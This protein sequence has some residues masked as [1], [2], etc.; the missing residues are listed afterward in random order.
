MKQILRQTRSVCP[1]CLKNLPAQ[2]VRQANGEIFLQKTCG[3]HGDYSVPVW[4]GL[5][6]FDLW[7]KHTDPLNGNAGLSC[8]DNCG[9]CGEHEIGTCCCLLEV[10]RRCNLSCRFC[11]ANGG[12]FV[13]DPTVEEL[14]ADTRDIVAKCGKVLLQLS[15][16]EPTLRSDLPHLVRYAKEAGCGYVQLNTNGIRLAQEP[17]YAKAL[18][19]AGLDIVFLQ[20]DG[21]RD[22]IYETLRGKP[23]LEC[24]KQA[25]Q[26]CGDLGIGVTLVP[27]VVP[28][29]NTD[30][31]GSMIRFAAEN[32][33]YVRGIHF[34]PVS[35]FGRYPNMPDSDGR[36][37]L[38]QLM[39]D[40]SDQT[41]IPMES[42]MPSRCDHPLCGFHANYLVNPN[43]TLR[44]LT[45][46]TH[47]AKEKG[48]ARDNR[49]Y[50]A[51]HWMR[52][53]QEQ[54]PTVELADEMDFDTFLYRLRHGS[55]NLSAMAFQ[56][57]MNL[58]MERLHRC[59]LHVYDHGTVKPFC[60]NYLTGID[61][62]N[63]TGTMDL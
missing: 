38:D 32:V 17:E 35:Y 41:G 36:Y 25:I 9:I 46:I 54:A 30:D 60:A 8:P 53:P 3:E 12:D 21:T 13:E 61:E 58:N 50:V 15:G 56:D 27:T 51:R 4:R 40:I 42:F 18:A 45:S 48:C 14:E 63:Q 5:V 59:S 62:E 31:L 1:V 10:T 23:L 7:T 44:A 55:L 26:V 11:F 20:F 49:E 43:G 33:P 28:G 47:S 22:N 2:L 29:V 16:G 6:D 37:T 39:A 52:Y 19:D 34:Q 24:K 57:A